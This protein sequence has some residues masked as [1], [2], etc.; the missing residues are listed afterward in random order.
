MSDRFSKSF[1]LVINILASSE[2][3]AF[4]AKL[5]FS[6]TVGLFSWKC[7]YF[8]TLSSYIVL[9]HYKLKQACMQELFNNFWATFLGQWDFSLALFF[10]MKMIVLMITIFNMC[11][12]FFQQECLDPEFFHILCYFA[13]YFYLTLWYCCWQSFSC[14]YLKPSMT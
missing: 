6:D 9:C 8:F 5:T 7:G 12:D 11:C 1:F 13:G 2:Y 4:P 3:P 10:V 14:S